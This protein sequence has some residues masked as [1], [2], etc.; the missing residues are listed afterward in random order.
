MT[1]DEK[2]IAL[3]GVMGTYGAALFTLIPKLQ[4]ISIYQKLNEEKTALEK[5]GYRTDLVAR[6]I[7]EHE[8]CYIGCRAQECEILRRRLTELKTPFVIIPTAWITDPAERSPYFYTIIMRGMDRQI[9]V[10]L[11]A[12]LEKQMEQAEQ[13]KQSE[14]EEQAEIDDSELERD[15]GSKEEAGPQAEN[16]ATPTE[17]ETPGGTDEFEEYG[18]QGP[19]E[20]KSGKSKGKN[21]GSRGKKK[22]NTSYQ[23]A[24]SIKEQEIRAYHE[25]CAKEEVL[26]REL[27]LQKLRDEQSDD[28]YK[29]LAEYRIKEE[30]L[31]RMSAED[32]RKSADALAEKTEQRRSM[33]DKFRSEANTGWKDHAEAAMEN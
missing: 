15:R 21:K 17:T 8:P 4:E 11:V 16:E 32:M 2:S 29:L 14:Q 7:R 3:I 1:L 27:E 26:R 24:H 9:A 6:D 18:G 13:K 12:E 10:D 20:E 31:K 23:Q 25:I 33:D 22:R 5:N 28:Y 19:K 30:D